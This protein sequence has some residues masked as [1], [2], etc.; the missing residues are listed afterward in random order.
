MHGTSRWQRF[1]SWAFSLLVAAVLMAV[2][3][4][5][6]AFAAVDAASIRTVAQ[7]QTDG[8]LHV[9]EQRTFVFDESRSGLVWPVTAMEADSQL[10]VSSVRFAHCTLQGGIDGEWTALPAVP[11]STEL[12]DLLEESAGLTERL[13]AQVDADAASTAGAGA[14]AGNADA[15]GFYADARARAIYLLFPP[16]EG[17]VVF[18]CDFTVTNAVRA[19]DDTAELYWDYV[20]ADADASAASVNV[21]VQLPMPEGMEAVAGQNVF[22]WGHGAD[23][24]VNVKA[25]GTVA[26]HVS[27]L[28]RGQYAQAHVLFPQQWL[29]NLSFKAQHAHA[30]TRLDDARAEEDAWTDTWSAWLMNSLTVDLAF[31]ILGIFAL[32]CAL[33]LFLAFGR[34]PKPSSL[35][36]AKADGGALCRSYEAPL[37]GRLLRWGHASTEDAVALLMQLIARGAVKAEALPSPGPLGAGF[38]DVRFRAAA[39]VKD[40]ARTPLDQEL[41]RLLFDVWGEGYASVTLTDIARHADADKLRFRE[42]LTA[43]DRAL[44]EAVRT[45]GFFDAR[46]ARVQRGVVI[47]G[48]ALLAG[49]LVVGVAGGSVV[50]GAA[51]LLSGGGCLVMGNYLARLAPAGAEAEASALSLADDLVDA[52]SLQDISAEDAPYAFALHSMPAVDPMQEGMLV[53]ASFALFWLAPRTG[54]GGKPM[55][56]LAR[57]LAHKL[58]EWG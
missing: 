23:G 4:S 53:D 2:A 3:L 51:L 25:D 13:E 39:R 27:K 32:S 35:Q 10:E 48:C 31:V 18:E 14:L 45:A 7:V 54:R 21:S 55:P 1:A 29:T 38:V 47:T 44:T 37:I 6:A 42:E 43:F 57:Q 49:A 9:V 19:F 52:G 28:G 24:T 20:P 50:R 40:V 15:A 16:T 12:R 22:A 26:F 58:E 8:A 34:E 41:M 30:G 46:S 36:G 17:R 56:S 11:F 5:Q 33:A